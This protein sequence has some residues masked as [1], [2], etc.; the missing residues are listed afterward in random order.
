[1]PNYGDGTVAAFGLSALTPTPTPTATP[2]STP[3]ATSTATPSATPTATPTSTPRPHPTPRS[4]PTP[5]ALTVGSTRGANR[6]RGRRTAAAPLWLESLECPLQLFAIVGGTPQ[7]PKKRHS[8]C[9]SA[10]KIDNS[11]FLVWR[12]TVSLALTPI[13]SPTKI[14][15]K[16]CT[17]PIG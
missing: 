11:R 16:W 5:R 2:T 6:G 15:C 17:L 1:M 14:L 7:I 13:C 8:D 9:D 3:T 12:I 10:G 4:R